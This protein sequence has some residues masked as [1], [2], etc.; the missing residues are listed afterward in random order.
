MFFF[1]NSRNKHFLKSAAL[2]PFLITKVHLVGSIHPKKV[3]RPCCS[4]TKRK[5]NVSAQFSCNH[6]LIRNNRILATLFNPNQALFK[7]TPTPQSI[8]GTQDPAW[9]TVDINTNSRRHCS[10]A[11]YLNPLD[12]FRKQ[13]APCAIIIIIEITEIQITSK[14]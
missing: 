7:R 9:E 1:V 11:R 12:G 3:V 10:A 5:N 6:V 13:N 4:R 2:E 14:E 8:C